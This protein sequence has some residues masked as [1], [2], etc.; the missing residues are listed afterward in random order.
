MTPR[1]PRFRSTSKVWNEKKKKKRGARRSPNGNE[2]RGRRDG[3]AGL[4]QGNIN[5][6]GTWC[7]IPGYWHVWGRTA[8]AGAVVSFCVPPPQRFRFAPAPPTPTALVFPEKSTTSIVLLR[9]FVLSR[10]FHSCPRR[11]PLYWQAGLI[12][13]F[14]TF[15]ACCKK[16]KKTTQCISQRVR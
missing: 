6:G 11:F 1:Q 15:L 16:Q 2:E 13:V 14:M 7:F 4:E 9:C 8:N 10:P 5:P 3:D 12:N